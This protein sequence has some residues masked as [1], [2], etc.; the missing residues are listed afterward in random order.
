M[1]GGSEVLIYGEFGANSVGGKV[2][3]GGKGI[4]FVLEDET[5][6]EFRIE[7]D[8]DRAGRRVFL[9]GNGEGMAEGE[10]HRGGVAG[11]KVS[12]ALR[13]IED[14]GDDLLKDNAGDCCWRGGGCNGQTV[15]AKRIGA[16]GLFESVHLFGE[17]VDGGVLLP[18]FFT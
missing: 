7:L 8:N 17:V 15:D 18:Q 12:T 16:K 3:G 13:G 11:G 6:D 1:V 2:S 5:A 10:V 4:A 9:G 14:G